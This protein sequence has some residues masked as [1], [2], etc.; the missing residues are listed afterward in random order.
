MLRHRYTLAWLSYLLLSNP[1]TGQAPGTML[2]SLMHGAIDLHIHS[3]PDIVERSV[4]D[5]E[6]TLSSAEMGMRA[7]VLKNHVTSTVARAK[8]VNEQVSE[9]E[10]FGGITLNRAVGGINP[11]AVRAM[12][13]MA[14]TRAKVVW[15]PTIDAANTK[16]FNE[17]NLVPELV[18]VLKIVAENDLV[19]ATGHLTSRQIRAVVK[20]A[21]Q[22]GI[23]NILVTHALAEDPNL[24]RD[25]L[26]W[27]VEQQVFIELTYLSYLMGPHAAMEKMRSTRHVT[28][29]EMV[30]LIKDL[31]A[32][33]FVVTSD[34]GKS[35]IERPTEGLR[36][37]LH[38]LRQAGCSPT[39]L[40]MML[41]ENPKKLLGLSD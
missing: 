9:I 17:G 20:R 18:E 5:L 19:L 36:H 31:G 32:G 10:V 28:L 34:L 30:D 37:F 2:D 27:L 13:A 23:Q 22:L 16:I 6:V 4:T 40:T 24:D 39:E 33:S 35:N 11:V 12:M 8:L 7:I 14:P 26:T 38:L 1:V 29:Q 41:K 21:R 3:A 25:M 15:L